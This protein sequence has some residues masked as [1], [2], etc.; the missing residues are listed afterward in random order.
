MGT[1]QNNIRGKHS[2][3]FKGLK[4]ILKAIRIKIEWRQ[5]L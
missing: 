4:N 2:S 5:L 3:G 1:F